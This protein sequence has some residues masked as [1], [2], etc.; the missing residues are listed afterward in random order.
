MSAPVALL[1]G[2]AAVLT[3][4]GSPAPVRVR[5]LAAAVSGPRAVR[6]PPVVALVTVGLGAV[7]LLA[8]PGGGVAAA[9]VGGV[10]WRARTAR[11]RDR[12][13]RTA[14][15]GLAEG[16]AGF[17]ADLRAGHPPAVA[18]G[19]A[20]RD[21]H[22]VC[23]RALTLVEATARLGGD[24]PGALRAHA[25]TEPLVGGHV[26]RLA[27]AWALADRHG[28]GLAGLAEAV[29]E[30][31]RARARFEGRLGAQLAGPRTTAGVL[32]VLPVVGLLLG[33]LLGARPWAVLTGTALGQGLLV[34]GAVL[35]AAGLEW[36]ARL[37]ARVVR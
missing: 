6:R 37:T 25:D 33:Q 26:R 17:A 10:L 22:A 4:P 13:R 34:V 30:D 24:V 5:A 32:A 1:L 21:A 18:A 20:A 12:A 7:V 36:S 15:A 23:A 28:I 27:D 19:A 3:W 35:V 31:L 14:V 9:V 29:A 11:R 8:G 2:A 16:L